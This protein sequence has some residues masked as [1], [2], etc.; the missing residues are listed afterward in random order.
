MEHHFLASYHHAILSVVLA[1]FGPKGFQDGMEGIVKLVEASP[2]LKVTT[3]CGCTDSCIRSFFLGFEMVIHLF[4]YV[5]M[6]KCSL[7]YLMTH[8]PACLLS[9][10][11][12]D[13]VRFYIQLLICPSVCADMHFISFV[14]SCMHS[15]IHSFI[16]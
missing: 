14:C 16:P 2:Y 3:T 10:L 11:F 8:L 6:H 1:Q 5:S 15:F 7:M 12:S 9:R 4:V 13:F